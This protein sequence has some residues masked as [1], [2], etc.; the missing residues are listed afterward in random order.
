MADSKRLKDAIDVVREECMSRVN[1]GDCPFYREIPF[2]GGQET[3]CYLVFYP[4][5]LWDRLKVG[6]QNDCSE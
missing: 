6:E 2:D 3:N 5:C 4:P 1:C